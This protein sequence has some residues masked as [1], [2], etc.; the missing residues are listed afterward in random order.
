MRS[1]G[2]LI[3]KDVRT[4]GLT[5]AELRR[6]QERAGADFPPDL[7]ELLKET[8][9]VG[10]EWPD[11]RDH[12][13]ETMQAWRDRV[14]DGIVFDVTRSDF[15]LAEWGERPTA[16]EEVREILQRELTTAPTLIPVYGHRAIPNDP[17][18][19]GNPVFSVV[20]TDVIVYG[21]N[22][23]EYLVNEFHPR[24]PGGSRLLSVGG[25]E[26]RFWHAL[27]RAQ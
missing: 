2:D 18:E 15:W 9:P 7:R 17:M 21:S 10:R 27:T 14:R 19:A 6:A 20:Q 25:R 24:P 16:I 8:L 11:W 23:R 5:S 4:A 12:P 13:A 22:L 26:I 3:P 1:L